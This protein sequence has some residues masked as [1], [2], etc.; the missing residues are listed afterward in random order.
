MNRYEDEE[1]FETEEEA[2]KPKPR[3]YADDEDTQ[4]E[5]PVRNKK[6]VEEEAEPADASKIIR[7]GWGAAEQAKTAD[8]PYAQRLRVTDDPVIIKFIEDEP[9]ATYRQHWIERNGQKSFTCI[10]DIDPKGCPLCDAGSRPA[11]RFAF[12]VALLSSDGEATIKSYEVGPRVIDQ[13]KN[14][15][16]DPRQGPLSKHYWAVSRTGKGPTSATNHQL[17]KERDLEEWAL[18]AIDEASMKSLKKQAYGPD[19]IQIPSRK[20]LS[21]IALEDLSE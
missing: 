1:E 7:R 17:V 2:P 14:F 21:Q 19:I 11:T 12:N 18:E 20:D 3:R 13:L 8:S 5:E 6:R 10:A 4:D 9:Y 16:T 15:H